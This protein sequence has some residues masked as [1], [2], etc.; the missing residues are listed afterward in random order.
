M[1]DFLELWKTGGFKAVL[2][3]LVDV[4]STDEEYHA[5]D[6]LGLEQGTEFEEVRKRYKELAGKW[7]PDHHLG[8]QMK[9]K[10]QEKFMKY[11]TA[12]K[13]LETI[14]KRKKKY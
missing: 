12:Y 3:E 1:Y 7:H 6:V 2:K 13:V 8:E 14:N 5:Y 10:A 4:I 9:K 11:E